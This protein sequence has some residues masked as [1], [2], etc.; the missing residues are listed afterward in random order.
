MPLIVIDVD[1]VTVLELDEFNTPPTSM[2]NVAKAAL[3]AL[4]VTVY[5]FPIFTISPATGNAVAAVPPY[6]TVDHV[7][8]TFH[9]ALALE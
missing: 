8:A 1:A 3:A 7:E 5:P 2:V 4:T 6:A 9:A